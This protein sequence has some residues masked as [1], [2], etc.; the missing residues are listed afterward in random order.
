MVT[1]LEKL[2]ELANGG[3]AVSSA[4]CA[5]ALVR[6]VVLEFGLTSEQIFGTEGPT[7]YPN[8]RKRSSTPLRFND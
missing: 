5:L 6:S 7:Q 3:E 2:A 8:R 4:S 1:D